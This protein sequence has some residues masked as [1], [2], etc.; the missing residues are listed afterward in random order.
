MS[1]PNENPS[2]LTEEGKSYP[3]T[4]KMY[5]NILSKGFKK[6]IKEKKDYY[7]LIIMNTCPAPYSPTLSNKKILDG[8]KKILK[9]DGLLIISYLIYENIEKSL[10]KKELSK[11]F[12]HRLSNIKGNYFYNYFKEIDIDNNDITILYKIKDIHNELLEKESFKIDSLTEQYSII[13]KSIIDIYR[14]KA[15]LKLKLEEELEELEELKELRELK[16][17]LELGELE[18]EEFEELEEFIKE[19]DEKINNILLEIK[20]YDNK[21][22]ELFYQQKVIKE[23]IKKSNSKIRLELIRR[24]TYSINEN[25]KKKFKNI[26][27]R[28]LYNK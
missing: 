22:K 10:T 28:T 25:S 11:I 12:K 8:L 13:K 19:S 4:H 20:L 16:K 2:K 17:K 18:E 27:K 14:N 7:S 6:F 15:K 3:V 1:N 23:N 5:F 21:I 9:K 24:K 26:I